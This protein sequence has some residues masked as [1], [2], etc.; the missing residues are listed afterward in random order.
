MDHPY[1]EV[2]EVL[3]KH[4]KK[5]KGS[6][7]ARGKKRSP[8]RDMAMIGGNLNGV[9]HHSEGRLQTGE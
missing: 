6:N 5:L 7:K 4:N 8:S 3:Q 1:N 9:R 2:A